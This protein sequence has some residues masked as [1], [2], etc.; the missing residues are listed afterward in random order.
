MQISEIGFPKEFVKNITTRLKKVEGQTRG[1]REMILEDRD[2]EEIMQ[3]LSAAS[4]ALDRV[5]ALLLT[6]G[7]EVCIRRQLSGEIENGD[8]M[9][10][11]QKMFMRYR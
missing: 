8:V 4:R 2:C 7:M 6:T 10:R 3:Q 5:S 9:A 11:I 1:L